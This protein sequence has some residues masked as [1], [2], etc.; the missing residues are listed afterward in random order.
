MVKRNATDRPV[1]VRVARQI[2]SV[3]RLVKKT[4]MKH[5]SVKFP[6]LLQVSLSLTPPLVLL[7]SWV[8]NRQ[9]YP[10]KIVVMVTLS[11]SLTMVLFCSMEDAYAHYKVS[12]SDGAFGFMMAA[13]L[14]F[15]TV[16]GKKYLPKVCLSLLKV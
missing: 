15:F 4:P 6:F 7:A 9:S 3:Q 13:S 14:A 16:H 11:C 12:F 1:F 2:F 10:D 5:K 8:T